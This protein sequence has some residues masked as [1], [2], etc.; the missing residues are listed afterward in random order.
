MVPAAAIE[1]GLASLP[2][3]LFWSFGRRQL[4]AINH[5]L[6]AGRCRGVIHATAFACGP[7]ALVG[8]LIEREAARWRT[9]LLR[10]HL[11]E[12]TGEAGFLTRLE[13]FLDMIGRR[14]A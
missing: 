14:R 5:L 7:E 13:A 1:E 4:G 8:E 3:S 9:P 12:H 2:K 11:D 6:A 10:L